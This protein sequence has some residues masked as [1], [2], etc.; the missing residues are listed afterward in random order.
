MRIMTVVGARPQFI[1]ASAL[2]RRLANFPAIT[3][4][5]IHTG[6]HYDYSMSGQFFDELQLPA[7]VCNLDVG[8]GKHGAQTGT[9]MQKLESLLPEMRP[10]M[11]LVYGDTN[12]TLAAALVAAKAGVPLAHVEA[13]LRSFRKNMP[14]E[15]NRIVTDRLSDYLFCPSQ[16][17]VSQLATE[18]IVKGVHAVGDIMLDTFRYA[19]RTNEA[20]CAVSAYHLTLGEYVLAT[21]HRAENTNDITRLRNIVEAL[22]GVAEDIQVVMPLH[23]RTRRI[24]KE[25]HIKLSVG[26][27]VIEPCS[28][29]SMVGLT[30]G[31]AVIATDSGG[32]QKEAYFAGV[33]CVT[34]RDE[35]EWIETLE[36]GWNRLATPNDSKVMYQAV[37]SALSFQRNSLPDPIYGDGD[38]AG[39]IVDVLAKSS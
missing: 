15:V 35:T 23:P 2:S 39:K 18:G 28:Y 22:G 11:L 34:L 31:S 30:S 9:I 25:S 29:L 20:E 3:E 27:R 26:I 6:Q 8:S 12:S 10:D 16:S 1:K 33:P 4:S 19:V 38:A 17:S 7:P 36:L 37:V 14:E 13:G 21:I 24:L 32:L 5:I